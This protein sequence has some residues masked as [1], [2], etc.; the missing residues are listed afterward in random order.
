MIT[1]PVA[2]F[3]SKLD[4]K[5]YEESTIIQDRHNVV[6]QEMVQAISMIRLMAS[7]QFWFRRIKSVKDE[8]LNNMYK[9]Q[10]VEKIASLI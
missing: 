5:L 1:A 3:M 9:I 6:M 10:V 8:Q 4:F 2:Y 7:E